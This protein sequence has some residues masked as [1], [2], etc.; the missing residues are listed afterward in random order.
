MTINI[1]IIG[2]TQTELIRKRVEGKNAV[3]TGE[4]TGMGLATAQQQ[5]TGI[6]L[7]KSSL[8]YLRRS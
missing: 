8:S 4:N 5:F 7:F 1:G 3:I 2:M 6:E